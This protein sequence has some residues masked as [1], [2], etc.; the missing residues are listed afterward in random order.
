MQLLLVFQQEAI[1]VLL[2][3]FVVALPNLVDNHRRGSLRDA[4]RAT[5]AASIAAAANSSGGTAPL[6]NISATC[7]YDGLAVRSVL[8]RPSPYLRL[9]LGSC[10]E[11]SQAN[12]LVQPTPGQA[13][14]FIETPRADYCI[15]AAA[16]P[17]A[18]WCG[19]LSVA[20]VLS[21]MCY[22]RWLQTRIVRSY[23]ERLWTVADYAVLVEGL[24]RGEV[25]SEQ[26]RSIRDD[27]AKFGIEENDISHIEIGCGCRR[28]HEILK[29]IAKLLVTAQENA[30]KVRAEMGKAASA[31]A[32]GADGGVDDDG[33]PAPELPMTRSRYNLEETRAALREARRELGALRDETHLTTGQAFIVFQ[34]E[35]TRNDVIRMFAN[36]GSGAADARLGPLSIRMKIA[37]ARSKEQGEAVGGGAPRSLSERPLAIKREQTRHR[38]RERQAKLRLAALI[39][40][41]DLLDGLKRPVQVCARACCP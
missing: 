41:V 12:L 30:V 16:H 3:L 21:F 14:P 38:L 39:S 40:S 26:E 11:Y 28:E 29:R 5:H 19:T 36:N 20:V 2:L 10:E 18:F 32:A 37:Q 22:L 23:D 25:P 8:P 27:L 34:R 9:A 6:A 24:Q 13:Y 33:G 35:H 15:D 7:G 1:G 4:C 17:Y 31:A